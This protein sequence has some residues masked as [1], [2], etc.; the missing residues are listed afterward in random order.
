[1][2]AVGHR[3]A[4]P[5]RPGRGIPIETFEALDDEAGA[6][7]KELAALYAGRTPVTSSRRL[8]FRVE[9]RSSGEWMLVAARVPRPAD[10]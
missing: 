1:V 7:G 10:P 2:R 6:C 4:D 5:G 9:R 8:D 3:R